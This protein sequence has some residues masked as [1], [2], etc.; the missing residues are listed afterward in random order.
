[1]NQRQRTANGTLD[2]WNDLPLHTIEHKFSQFE[3]YN[4]KKKN[5][6]YASVRLLAGWFRLAM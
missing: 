1:M 4:A 3:T 5:S 6:M 2:N